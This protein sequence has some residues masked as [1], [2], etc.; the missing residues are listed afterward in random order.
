MDEVAG[1]DRFESVPDTAVAR[2]MRPLPP[3]ELCFDADSAPRH[4][5]QES[6][7]SRRSRGTGTRRHP[8][9]FPHH[10]VRAHRFGNCPD[11]VS[12]AIRR[13]APGAG[14][15]VIDQS[16]ALSAMFASK[17]IGDALGTVVVRPDCPFRSYRAQR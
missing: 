14:L 2:R 16:R 4:R 17:G 7:P 6:I 9:G 10:A 13:G 11:C 3:I 8:D 15:M 12:I 5:R 1:L